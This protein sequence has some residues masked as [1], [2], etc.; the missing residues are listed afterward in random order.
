MA[1]PIRVAQFIN[2]LGTGGI[3]ALV[4]NWHKHI[5]TQRVQF[6]YIV[7][8]EGES[9]YEDLV[10]TLG[11][12]IIPLV[13]EKSKFKICDYFK[14]FYSFYVLLHQNNFD[15]IHFHASSQLTFIYAF[16]SWL[17][18]NKILFIHSHTSA[19]K[20]DMSQSRRILSQIFLRLFVGLFKKRYACSIEAGKWMYGKYSFEVMKNGIPVKSFTYSDIT[21]ISQRQQ[22]QI[23]REF[24]I[25]HVGRFEYAKNHVFLIDI[26]YEIRQTFR[27]AILLLIGSGALENEIKDKVESL[28][29][30]QDVVF[31]GNTRRI[32]NL[33]QAMD[34][35]IFPSIYEGFGIVAIEAQAAALKIIASD[36]I[37]KS[38]DIT[39]YIHFFSLKRSPKEWANLALEFRHG[40]KRKDVSQSIIEKGY[41]IVKI[42]NYLM[43]QY[44]ASSNH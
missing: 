30:Q 15:V 20:S 35:M 27:N 6:D 7:H 18:G 43:E 16:I 40:Y 41:D 26:F 21:R 19:F 37:P 14:K 29:L 31:Y 10:R 3:E 22:L 12:S 33:M 11:G 44:I 42:T 13:R 9:H 36:K 24:V 1:Q 2:I 25:G 34:V 5:D 32:G 8:Y 38:T 39:S 4:T 28:G 23:N 17:A